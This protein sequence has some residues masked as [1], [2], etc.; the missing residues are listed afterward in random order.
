M[1]LSELTKEGEIL[2]NF[3]AYII[4]YIKRVGYSGRG[5]A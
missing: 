4:H 3:D 1:N 5:F 2:S